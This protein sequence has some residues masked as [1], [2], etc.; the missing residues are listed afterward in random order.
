MHDGQNAG[1]RGH[2]P[3]HARG[4]PGAKKRPWQDSNLQPLDS[5]SSALS[6]APQGHRWYEQNWFQWDSNPRL[7]METR[8]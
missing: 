2:G 5:K 8:T 7:Q 1:V 4:V 3:Q 6:I